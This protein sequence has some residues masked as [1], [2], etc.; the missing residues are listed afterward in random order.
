MARIMLTSPDDVMRRYLGEKL[1]KAGH[2]VTRVADYEVALTLLCETYHDV[3]LTAIGS[4][5]PHGLAFAHEAR[6][7]DPEM[8]V[9]FITGFSIVPL[10]VDDEDEEGLNDRLGPPAHLNHLIDEVGRLLAA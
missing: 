1:K 2:F 8:R 4:D 6:R 3:L 5:D 9:M 7:I 10:L